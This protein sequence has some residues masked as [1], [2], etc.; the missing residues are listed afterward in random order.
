MKITLAAGKAHLK[1]TEGGDF[2]QA[3]YRAVRQGLMEAESI[4][5]E[6]YYEFRMEIPQDSIGRAMTDIE[7]MHGTCD[8]PDVVGGM[9][10]LTGTAPV[11]SMS[12]Y[13]T[14]ITSYTKGSGRI[15]CTLK[16]Y[17]P[18][19]NA[20]EVIE[21]IGYR[22]SGD[23]ENPSSSVFCAHG[24]GFAVEWNEVKKYMHLESVL[25]D[26]RSGSGNTE[27]KSDNSGTNRETRRENSSA[28][29]DDELKAIFERTYGPVKQRETNIPKRVVFQTKETEY[30]GSSDKNN[31]EE[32]LLVDGYNVI[33]AWEDLRE[34]AEVSMDAARD[35]LLDIMCNYQ[36][37]RQC[38]LIVVFDAYKV[39]G[40]QGEV[41][42]YHNIEVVFTKEAET[43][44][45][46]IEKLAHNIGRKYRVTVATSDGLEQIIIMGQGCSLL[47]SREL[48]LE[49]E[50]LNRHI[51]EEYLEK[52]EKNHNYLLDSAADMVR[53]YRDKS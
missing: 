44:D 16:G 24:A 25:P 30:K 45:Q 52:Q 8:S 46:Y 32:Y 10:V 2:R 20:E 18:C 27:N 22:A 3:T 9:A 35:R 42:R 53:D 28:A 4:L 26:Y 48:K 6:P 40:F 29:T 38:T 21:K 49:V 39:R 1:H 31:T 5:L 14:E 15:F 17:A 23:M 34:L 51:R 41:T 13:Q 37:Y 7:R 50:R 11:S 12:G 47:S 19:R 33:Y 36:G 43:A